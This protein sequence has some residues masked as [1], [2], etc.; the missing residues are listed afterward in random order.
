MNGWF[1]ERIPAEVERQL[2]LG[3]QAPEEAAQG[4]EEA[5]EE[6]ISAELAERAYAR[7]EDPWTSWAAARSQNAIDL[8]RSQMAIL[9]LLSFIGPSTDERIAD[10]YNKR[11]DLPK[12]LP[13]GLRTRRK[14][15]VDAGRVCDT[16]RVAPLRTGRRGIVWAA[17]IDDPR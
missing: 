4:P 2:A 3:E 9:S 12:Q 8:R 7:R 13:S 15:L 14:E 5:F 16:G 11:S 6:G 17:V 1:Q 10:E